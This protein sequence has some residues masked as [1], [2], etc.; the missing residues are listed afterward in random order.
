MLGYT[1]NLIKSTKTNWVMANAVATSPR[2]AVPGLS[3]SD[4]NSFL[5]FGDFTTPAED[6]MLQSFLDTAI[7]M[8][9]KYTGYEPAQVTYT[10]RYDRH[11]RA[12]RYTGGIAGT[13]EYSE[14]IEIPR[15]PVK[16][17]DAVR[18]SGSPIT[19]FESDILSN[20]ARVA[21]ISYNVA[22]DYPSFA[23]IEIDITAGPTG[24]VDPTFIVGA[25]MLSSYL[26]NNRGCGTKNAIS[27][28][29]AGSMVRPLKVAMGGL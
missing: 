15:R 14:W 19:D 8:L 13:G 1:G 28:S 10:L 2:P 21:L 20:P 25:L 11:P 24:N 23:E 9:V 18:A 12:L 16:S 5:G 3:V 29:G 22:F 6:A 26:Y 27:E 4:L 17:V 7:Q